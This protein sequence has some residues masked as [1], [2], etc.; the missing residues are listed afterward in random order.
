GSKTSY[1]DEV[2]T[3]D[4][5]SRMFVCSDTDYCNKRQAEQAEAKE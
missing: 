3:D 4:H 2:I 5:G 1:L